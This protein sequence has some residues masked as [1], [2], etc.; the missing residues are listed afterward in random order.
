MSLS[1]GQVANIMSALLGKLDTQTFAE[2]KRILECNI[3]DASVPNGE[4]YNNIKTYSAEL[5]NRLME[6]GRGIV[7]E[8]PEEELLAVYM[9][10]GKVQRLFNKVPVGGYLAA[11]PG[12]HKSKEGSSQLTISLLATDAALNILPVHLNGSIHG[13]EQWDNRRVMAA[14]DKVFL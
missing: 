11:M 14:M 13:E 3:T 12:I 5:F 2:V 9:D 4:P 8:R 10:R 7:E 1:S 6:S